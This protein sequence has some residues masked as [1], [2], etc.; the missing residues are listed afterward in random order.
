MIVI[1]FVMKPAGGGEA[2]E[3]ARLTITNDGTGTK[4]LGNYDF[5]ITGREWNGKGTGRVM[6]RGHI[7][8]YPRTARSRWRL[9]QR[10]LDRAFG[11]DDGGE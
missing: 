10:C 11:H 1:P 4:T 5:V 9:I 7:R 8:N 2:Y 6:R 3:L